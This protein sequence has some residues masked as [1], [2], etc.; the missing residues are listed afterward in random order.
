MK[1]DEEGCVECRVKVCSGGGDG[2]GGGGVNGGGSGGGGS[3]GVG[4]VQM[5]CCCCT[6]DDSAFKTILQGPSDT[7]D[8]LSSDAFTFA[9]CCS[10]PRTASVHVLLAVCVVVGDVC[11]RGVG[12][13]LVLLRLLEVV[14]AFCG[15][16]TADWLC[17]Y[18]WTCTDSSGG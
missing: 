1:S 6:G 16:R 17:K 2:C 14:F 10:L 11:E 15:W 7:N 13:Q 12:A 8:P 18:C 5:V 9:K 4:C 3:G